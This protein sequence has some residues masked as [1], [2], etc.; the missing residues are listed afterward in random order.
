V[1][2][3][4]VWTKVR[5]GDEETFVFETACGEMMDFYVGGVDENAFGYCPFC[6][7]VIEECKNLEE[8]FDE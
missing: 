3:H 7:G 6:G 5:V 4:C 2:D 8:T 1:K